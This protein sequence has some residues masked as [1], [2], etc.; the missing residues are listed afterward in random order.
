MKTIKGNC[1]NLH[2]Y[3]FCYAVWQRSINKTV[4][5]TTYCHTIHTHHSTDC[6]LTYGKVWMTG[7]KHKQPTTNFKHLCPTY[8]PYLL[9]QHVFISLLKIHTQNCTSSCCQGNTTLVRVL[10]WIHRNWGDFAQ[11]VR[12]K[13]GFPSFKMHVLITPWKKKLTQCQHRRVP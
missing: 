12:H 11:K 3:T 9:R 10:S 1:S 5:S 4:V 7:M 2:F 13:W 8:A 6:K